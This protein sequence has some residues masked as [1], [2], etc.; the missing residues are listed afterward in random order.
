M[1]YTT[2]FAL[3]APL[4]VACKP[5]AHERLHHKRDGDLLTSTSTVWEETTVTVD[6]TMTVYGPDPNS[7]QLKAAAGNQ[8]KPKDNV[9]QP[10]TTAP[11]L[12][13]VPKVEVPKPSTPPPAPSPQPSP[14]APQQ[15]AP[16]KKVLAE[17]PKANVVAQPAPKVDPPKTDPPKVEPAK[18]DPAKDQTGGGGGGGGGAC[19][20]VGGK[21]MASAVTIYN[22]VGLG[23]CGWANDTNSQD[24]FAL[25]KG[26]SC[27]KPI[28]RPAL[29]T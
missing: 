12:P 1:R 2:I 26:M 11:A 20:D 3:G 5:M 9:A 16:Q 15:A 8:D 19:G 10:T 29:T 28:A 6:V 14:P 4:L 7:P 18:V 22:D 21:C 25:S 27:V 17:V 23:A 13:P 24:F